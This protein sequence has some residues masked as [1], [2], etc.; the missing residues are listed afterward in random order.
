MEDY[1][2]TEKYKKTKQFGALLKLMI[3]FRVLGMI[4][5]IGSVII[6]IWTD[7]NT[8]WKCFITATFIGFVSWR[9]YVII[10][11]AIRKINV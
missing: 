5:M 10:E 4:G 3:F 2:N 11:R 1:R 6:F 9:F 7:F 8:A